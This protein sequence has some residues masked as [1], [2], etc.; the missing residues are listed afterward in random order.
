MEISQFVFHAK[1]HR[2]L[3]II[4]VL[5]FAS[6]TIV[7]QQEFNAGQP[8]PSRNS[9]GASSNANNSQYFASANLLKTLFTGYLDSVP[10]SENEKG[11]LKV[12]IGAHVLRLLEVDELHQVLRFSVKAEIVSPQGL[13]M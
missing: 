12:R 11:P 13:L 5:A 9:R 4:A 8:V 7:A 2:M 3:L 1:P 6:S 10:Q